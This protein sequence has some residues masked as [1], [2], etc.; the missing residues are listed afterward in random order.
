MTHTVA[1]FCTTVQLTFSVSFPSL[2]R[3]SLHSL[4]KISI[5]AYIL[6]LIRNAYDAHENVMTV[7]SIFSRIIQAEEPDATITGGGRNGLIHSS[8]GAKYIGKIGSRAEQEQFAGEAE[9]LKAM[10][11]AA[12]GLVPRFLAGGIIDKQQAQSDNEIGRPYFL[13]EYKDLSSLTDAS[14]KILGKRLATEMHQYKSTEGFGFHVPTFCGATKQANGWYDS[15]AECYDA[16]IEGL[17]DK[18][19]TRG[20]FADLCAKG[21]EVRKR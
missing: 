1:V 7:H 9:S 19:E 21:K 15:W 16:L 18:L 11:L 4:A 14:A 10:N 20:G 6:S 13:S 17:L 2:D 12:P 3:R 5:S 8:T